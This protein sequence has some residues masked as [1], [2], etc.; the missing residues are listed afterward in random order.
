MCDSLP[1]GGCFN[2]PL[3]SDPSIQQAVCNNC[4]AGAQ[5]A[6]RCDHGFVEVIRTP[7]RHEVIVN[8]YDGSLMQIPIASAGFPCSDGL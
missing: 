2:V 6:L 3:K 1:I 8:F 7:S 4:L 5:A